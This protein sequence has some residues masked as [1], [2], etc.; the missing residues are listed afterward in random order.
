MGLRDSGAQRRGVAIALVLAL[1]GGRS[2]RVRY[3]E[4]IARPLATALVLGVF[5]LLAACGQSDSSPTN[6][7]PQP[8]GDDATASGDISAGGG[9]SN[10][11]RTDAEPL[12]REEFVEQA[13]LICAEATESIE[14]LAAPGS[15][16]ELATS[17][18]TLEDIARRE[19]DRL[20]ALGQ[21]VD[22]SERLNP[23]YFR[24][25]E[26]QLELLTELGAA[27]QA[28]DLAGARD[29]LAEAAALNVE[30]A[31]IAIDYGLE[32]CTDAAE[33]PDVPEIGEQPPAEPA[34]PTDEFVA[35]ADAICSDSRVLVDQLREPQT[36]DEAVESLAEIVAISTEEL[37]LLS[38]LDPPA[39][40]ADSYAELLVLRQ[41]QIAAL[42]L[43]GEALEADDRDA[44]SVALLES[45]QLNDSADLLQ[46]E[47]GFRVCGTEPVQVVPNQ[48]R[49]P[50]PQEEPS[51]P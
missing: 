27:A 12:T 51:S 45:S 16:S 43:F 47:L 42:A 3:G 31:S 40:L 22:P 8:P 41:E 30:A 5:F 34:T 50:D 21:P 7:A 48:R 18:P 19:L 25:L 23:G 49:L 14:A 10:A 37:R 29:V 6:P 35:A 4:P 28:D 44:A 26:Q 39:E 15:L 2:S 1:A 17:V 36:V 20:S 33:P 24:L 11:P 32:A 9:E 38:E 13:N 46:Q